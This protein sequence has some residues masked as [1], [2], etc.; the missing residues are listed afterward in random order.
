MEL[1]IIVVNSIVSF[2]VIKYQNKLLF[3]S[4]DERIERLKK[5]ERGA[6][7]DRES[8]FFHKA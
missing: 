8:D 5:R 4:L 2:L 1:I 3:K 7:E 6:G